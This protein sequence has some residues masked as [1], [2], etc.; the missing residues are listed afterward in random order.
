MANKAPSVSKSKKYSSKYWND[1]LTRAEEDHKK[2]FE[3]ADQSI[4]VY[5]TTHS[6]NTPNDP[7]DLARR[8]NCWW[9]VIQTL[10]PAYFSSTPRVEANLRKK[11]GSTI[12]QL[13]ATTIERATQYCMEEDFDFD[14]V[15]LNSALSLLLTGRSILWARYE[16]DFENQDKE[17]GLLKGSDGKLV[18]ADGNPYDGDPDNIQEDENGIKAVANLDVKT[19]ERAILECL[20]YKDY[21]NSSARN[22]AEIEWRAKKAY[23]TEEK[24]IELFGPDAAHTLKYDSFPDTGSRDKEASEDLY[25]GKAELWEIWCEESG[26]V[27]WKQK[28]GDNSFMESSD[29][30][31]KYEDFYPCEVINLSI[32]PTST[33]PTS[34]Y[35]HVRDQI[36]EVEKL[37]DR[38]HALIGAVRTNFAYDATL[39]MDL[40]GLLKGD[41]KGIPIKNWP[42]YKTRGGLASG[43]EFLPID[44]YVNALQIVTQAREMALDKLFESMKAS[45]LLRGTSDPTKT[46]TANRLES[47]WSSLGL[48]VR[49]NQF[50]QFV[51][52]AIGKLGTI[53]A[54][55]FDPERILDMA[56]VDELIAPLIS[57]AP[58]MPAPPAP[59]PQQDPS[60]QQPQGPQ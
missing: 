35:V 56:A 52:K 21:L 28:V 12:F 29:P 23:L 45:D 16:A 18:D 51:G 4:N 57:Q 42:A 13:A 41:L 39:G 10:L 38:E 8:L 7:T 47:Q 55:Q 26:K 49:Q 36:L 32:D 43:M 34:D 33:I 25:D 30:P 9:Y 59:Q 2:F 14:I 22:E 6:F 58:P 60:Q 11:A 31:Q 46:A 3:W 15:G 20:Y 53:I 27:Y 50:S 5:N 37:T 44:P 54:Q 24:A 48:I 17:Y 19:G 40:E 1:Q